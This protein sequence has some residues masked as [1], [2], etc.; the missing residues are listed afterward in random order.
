MPASSEKQ[1]RFM[2]LCAHSPS[3][4]YKKCPPKSVAREFMHAD[5]KK[6]KKK[7]DPYD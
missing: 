5:K 3:K 2:R 1:A 4:A 7:D 6:K